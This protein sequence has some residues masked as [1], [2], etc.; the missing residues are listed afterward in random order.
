MYAIVDTTENEKILDIA[1]SL[2]KLNIH[3]IE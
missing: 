1:E 2:S 3:N